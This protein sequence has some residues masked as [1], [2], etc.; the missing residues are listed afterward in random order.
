MDAPRKQQVSLRGASAKE[1]TRDA[2]L[3]KVSQERELR[4]YAKRAAAAALFIQRVWRRF[5][6]TKTVSLQLQQEWEMAVN[7]YTGLMTANWISNNL[8]R[9]FLFFITRISTQHE[10][11]H[12]KRIDSMK[13]C[14]TIVLESLK[15][16]DSK[17]NFCFLAIGTTE[18]RRM[19]RYQARK[20]TSLSFL[21]LSEFSE[22]PSGA[23]DIT[24]VTSLSMRVLVMLTDL[25][26]WKGITNNNHFDA[27]LAVKDLIQF[28]G[29]DKSG[30]YVSIGRY[31]SALENHSSQSKTITQAD[32][33]FFVTASAITLAVRPFYLTNYDAEAPH[34]LDFNNAAEQYIVSLLTIPWLV[35]RLPLVLLPALKHKS[36]LFP[37]FQ[38]LLILKEKVLMEMSGFIKSEIPVS[39][40]AI[41][42]VG[43]ALA[44]IIC[45]ATVNENESFNQGLDHGLYVHVVIT[46]SEA[47]LACLDNIGWVRKKKK[48]LQTDVENSTQPIDAV[49]HEGEATDESLI[50]SYMDQF[51]PVCQQWHLKILLASIDRDSNNKAATV[52][53]SSLECLGN[54]E[55]CDIALFYSNLLRI[56]SVLS[57]IRG[58]LSVLNMLSFTPGF[59]VRLWSVLEGSFFSGDKH[60]SDNYTSENSKHKVF[61]KMQKQVSKDGPNKWVNVLHRFTGKTQAATDCTNFIDNHT[62][63]SRVNED[64]SD[65]WDIEPMRNGPQ[66]IP[67]NMFSMLHLFCATYSHLLLVLD[68]IE[69]YEKQVPFQIEQQRR[70]ASMLNTLVYNGL[71][72]VGGHHNKPLMD[73]AVRCLHLLYERDCR[74]PFCPPALWLSPA[75]KSRPPIAVAARTHEALAANLR[76]DD[77]S[78]S[79]SAGSVV[80]IVPHVFPFEERVEMFREFIKMDKASRKMAGEISEPDS[81]A[82]EIVV[83]RGHIVEDGFR[84]LNSLGSRL[85]SSIHVSFVSECGLLEAG[86]DYGG[87]SKEFLTDLSKA[88]FAPEYGLFSQTSTSDRLLI[89]TASARYLENGLQMIEFLGRVVGKALYEGILL[90]YSFSHVFVQKLLGRYSFL[91][92]L[93]TLD[94]ELYR[95]LMYVKNYDGDVME[96]CLDFTVTEESLGKRY[97]VELKSGGKDISVT[98]ENKMQYMHAMADYKL[99]QQMLPFSNAFYRGLT[100]LISPSWLKLFN[101]SEFN[102]LLSGGNYDIDVDDLKNNTRYTGGYNEGSRTIK[103]FWEVIKGFEPEERCMLL[104]FVTSCS[105]APLLGFKYLQPPLTIHKVA[106]DVPLWAT[107]GGQDVDRLPSASTCYNTLKL[108]TYKRPGTLR[109]K[110]LYAISSNAGFELS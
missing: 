28:M 40:K 68:D 73:C 19:W 80:T 1:I 77:S 72:H 97:V 22:C 12:C 59:L 17:L 62:E 84:Q 81:R 45:L 66:G 88:A 4:N 109:A 20:L 58:S 57:P 76:Y 78:A 65:V 79:L 107:I 5:K 32:E 9:P 87:L 100:D 94:P 50:L 21:I 96:L 46:L 110:L 16:S 51:R 104:K 82:I 99:N 70:I 38:T 37:C 33:I 30:C 3:Q 98:N 23:Q 63:S 41:P 42:P 75:R 13:L 43:W 44:N 29:S 18:E 2:L 101:A 54:L 64:S 26:G 35:Q 105:R 56:F 49:Q 10:K 102:Q 7:H 34:M 103:I 27:D 31:I 52:L 71:S 8:L 36:I 14:F 90:D 86:L 93:S 24:I 85:K 89:P 39:F 47:L 6:V 106:C 83:R 60:N 108:P 55:L 67:K 25:K 11:V 74:H 15:S 92:E 61:E 69:F 53:S 95:N 48:A 91:V